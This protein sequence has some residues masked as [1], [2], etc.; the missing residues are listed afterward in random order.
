MGYLSRVSQDLVKS[1]SPG[2]PNLLVLSSTQSL[3]VDIMLKTELTSRDRIRLLLAKSS[4]CWRQ[5]EFSSSLECLSSATEMFL[6]Q[7]RQLADVGDLDSLEQLLQSTALSVVDCW[8]EVGH[9][10]PA[11][12]ARDYLLALAEMFSKQFPGP[13]GLF[14]S[15]TLWLAAK[16][17][18]SELEGILDTVVK[19]DARL[20]GEKFER[21]FLVKGMTDETKSFFVTDFI[22]RLAFDSTSS[23][24]DSLPTS[25]PALVTATAE[26]PV[27]KS[28]SQLSGSPPTEHGSISEQLLETGNI[29]EQLLD[30]TILEL[31]STKKVMEVVDL[32]LSENRKGQLPSMTALEALSQLLIDEGDLTHL[33]SLHRSLPPS[34]QQRELTYMGLGRVRLNTIYRGWE[35]GKK[36]ISWVRL[37]ELYR[38]TCVDQS[39]GEI[40]L[41][42][43]EKVLSSAAR[44]IKLCIEE[45]ILTESEDVQG[46]DLMKAIKVGVSRIM[47]EHGDPKPL[48]ALWEALFF[49]P[50]WDRQ[51]EADSLLLEIPAL[52][53]ALKID[54]VLARA[55]RYKAEDNYRRLI[56]ICLKYETP[57]YIK[58]RVFEELLALQTRSY[59]LGGGSQTIKTAKSLD[60]RITADYLQA[61]LDLKQEVELDMTT[62][63]ICRLKKYFSRTLK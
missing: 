60:I 37:V 42:T 62:N 33:D 31:V 5:K 29:S 2:L 22:R 9:R 13:L 17:V 54:L 20:K 27:V 1:S 32:V 46:Q 18:K 48:L 47:T 15:Y 21:C 12:P 19:S 35:K 30:I 59:N 39:S 34:C 7:V 24:S 63:I 16:E 43:G 6:T 49:A 25:I 10:A 8:Q 36:L 58:S 57:A 56:E 52:V 41:Q 45:T 26:T 51:Q 28:S 40:P 38:S 11:G 61:Y 14:P 4:L 55:A 44:H 3:A 50:A 23:Q 53:P